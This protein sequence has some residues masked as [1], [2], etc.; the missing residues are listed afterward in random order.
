MPTSTPTP[1][2]QLTPAPTSTP[3]VIGGALP[4]PLSGSVAP[5]AYYR[6][7][8]SGLEFPVRVTF[9]LPAGWTTEEGAFLYKDKGQPG[10]V[11]FVTWVVTHV[12][13][14]ACDWSDNSL[15]EI[16]RPPNGLISALASQKGRAATA[17][18]W[19]WQGTLGGHPAYGV[20]L[21]V[22]ADLDTATC[23]SGNL[24][25]WPD[26][27]PNFLGGLCCNKPGN[28]DFIYAVDVNGQTIA[29]VAR[30]YAESTAQAVAELDAILQ[31]LELGTLPRPRG[32]G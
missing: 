22:P 11:M 3:V 16:V 7:E 19:P 29:V 4:F 23:T 12:Y 27:G 14:D 25:Y 1:T 6:E 2:I 30:H 13:T 28:T 21:E 17:G 20:E 31:W 15:V 24:R 26:P 32:S 8:T 5:G 10:E 18:T 9:T